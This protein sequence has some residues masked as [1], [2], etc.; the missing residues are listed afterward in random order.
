MRASC[1]NARAVVTDCA[2]DYHFRMGAVASDGYR[3]VE[4]AGPGRRV[5][6]RRDAAGRAGLL[7]VS[8]YQGEEPPASVSDA[9]IEALGAG[10]WRVS[11]REGSVRFT[12]RAVDE[13]EMRPAL[14]EGL[15]RPFAL[16]TGERVVARVL[17]AMLRL[18]GGA[19]LL[20]RWHARRSP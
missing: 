15:H 19:R 8:G 20:R 3:L 11:G 16:R 7:V 5:Q 10:A 18:P 9:R 17:L 14:F 1:R 4:R 6:F 12:A 13:I 2:A